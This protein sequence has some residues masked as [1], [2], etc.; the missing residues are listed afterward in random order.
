MFSLS[1]KLDNALTEPCLCGTLDGEISCPYCDGISEVRE[2]LELL[3]LV[4]SVASEW[5]VCTYEKYAC[6]S[7][8][9][10][11]KD[12]KYILGYNNEE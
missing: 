5:D 9:S 10:V 6:N 7:W 1:D 4:V 11:I 8:I 12:I 2:A 3:E